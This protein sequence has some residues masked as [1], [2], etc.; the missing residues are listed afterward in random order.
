MKRFQILSES[1]GDERIVGIV[2]DLKAVFT[3]LAR[4][5]D[6]IRSFSDTDSAE[7]VKSVEAGGKNRKKFAAVSISPIDIAP[8]LKE[9]L[10]D[11]CKTLIMTSATLRERDSFEFQKRS[12]G[13]EKNERIAE[14]TVPSP[15][16]YGRQALLVLPTDIAE[17]SATETYLKDLSD[18]VFDFIRAAGGGALV[19]FTSYKDLEKV[20]SFLA[21]K[22]EKSGI[23]SLTQGDA[24][25]EKLLADF[26]NDKNAVL[27]G[28]DSFREGV[29]IA[30]DA[31]RLVIITRLPFN[32]PNEPVFHSRMEAIRNT[33]RDAFSE[34][35]V[36]ISVINF[37]QAFGRLIR[38]AADMGV[39]AVLD[40]R[41]VRKSYGKRFVE[42]IPQCRI[43]RGRMRKVVGDAED[44]FRSKIS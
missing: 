15:F 9:K 16:D 41:I 23:K 8:E 29:D 39:V 28:T 12:L 20:S 3:G 27:F 4:H 42:S 18:A 30:G 34:Y 6:A 24:P 13:L 7:F 21:P 5:C 43:V 37:R 25:R 44:F 33:G 26:K 35:A 38:T 17:P 2:A 1:G 14:I 31:L 22:L 11:N 19:L 32:V 36:P 10:Y 40:S